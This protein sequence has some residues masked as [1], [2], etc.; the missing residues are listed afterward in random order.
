MAAADGGELPYRVFD[1]CIWKQGDFYYSLSA[2]QTP[3]GPGGKPVAADFLL[4][5][6]DLA[7]WEYLHPFVEDDHYTLVGDDGACPYFWPIGESHILLFFSHM[8][9]GQYLIGDYDTERQKL[10][11]TAGGKF[12]MGPVGPSGVHAPSATPDGEDVIV[13]F[14]MNPGKP[15][16]GWN[17]IM[18]LPRRLSLDEY[19][20]LKMRPVE[21]V[22]GLRGNHASLGPR[23]IEANRDQ[24]LAELGGDAVE[25]RASIAPSSASMVALDVLVSPEREEFTPHRLLPRPRLLGQCAPRATKR[26]PRDP[27]HLL[28]LNRRR[29]PQP[30]PRNRLRAA[31]PGR[32][33]RTHGVRGSKRGGNLRQR[34]P[35][36]GGTGLSRTGRQHRNQPALPRLADGAPIPRCLANGLDLGVSIVEASPPRNVGGEG[37][38]AFPPRRLQV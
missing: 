7:H 20:E 23:I 14:N 34:S 25:I 11:V 24:P 21:A 33:T 35:M 2:G 26:Q 36:R 27:R 8:S 10:K 30:S 4:R 28:L 6:K 19:G 37:S 12:N 9:G 17:Q 29:R 3:N 16:A 13:I 32:A 1:P 5:S 15:T 38:S 18:T 22:Q 31:S